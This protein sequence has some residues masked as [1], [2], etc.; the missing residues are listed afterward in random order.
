MDQARSQAVP[1][2]GTTL[3]ARQGSSQG[4]R[5]RPGSPGIMD[6]HDRNH[7]RSAGVDKAGD[8]CYCL[9]GFF[10]LKKSP[11]GVSQEDTEWPHTAARGGWD[12]CSSFP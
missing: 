10:S 6:G 11:Q 5:K 8:D 9:D 1:E 2:H 7:L 12:I 3:K 4:I